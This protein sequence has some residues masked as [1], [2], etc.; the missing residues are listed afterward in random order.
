MRQLKQ[1][2]KAGG[3][4]KKVRVVFDVAFANLTGH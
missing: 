2:V 1:L 4:N 3:E